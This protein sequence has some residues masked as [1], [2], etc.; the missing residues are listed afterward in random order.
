[1]TKRFSVRVSLLKYDG[2]IEALNKLFSDNQGAFDSIPNWARELRIALDNESCSIAYNLETE[3]QC[4]SLAKV[5]TNLGFC[6]I[7]IITEEEFSA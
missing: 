7:T 1:M 5:I 4:K 2:R 3:E 6:K